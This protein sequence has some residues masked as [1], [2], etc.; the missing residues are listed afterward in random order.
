MGKI[1][2]LK[3]KD[4]A[5]AEEQIDKNIKLLDEEKKTIL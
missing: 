2:S 5:E 3:T 4:L 1:Q